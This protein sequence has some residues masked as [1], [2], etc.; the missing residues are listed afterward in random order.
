MD[1][2]AQHKFF[3][4][5]KFYA[6]N[7]GL[8]ELI[9][10]NISDVD[11]DRVAIDDGNR[12]ITFSELKD[13]AL[14]VASFLRSEGIGRGSRVALHSP[15]TTNFASIFFG[16]LRSGACCVF[17]GSKLTSKEISR[18]LSIIN[19][20]LIISVEE[21]KWKVHQAVED[22]DNSFVNIISV[23]DLLGHFCLFSGNFLPKLPSD[24]CGDDIAVISSSSGTTGQ[25]KGVVLSHRNLVSNVLQINYTLQTVLDSSSRVATPLPFCH[26][27]GATVLLCHSLYIRAT[28]FTSKD[29]L[30]LEFL[31]LIESNEIDTA[32]VIPSILQLLSIESAVDN[33]DLTSLRR[34]ICGASP[35][36][37]EL[38]RVVH[39]RFGCIIS[40]GYGMTETS[41]V[42]HINIDEEYA[43][44]N[45]GYPVIGTDVMISSGFGEGYHDVS[46]VFPIRKTC[47]NVV[48]EIWVRGPQVM[49]EYFE[50]EEATKSSFSNGWL[51][52]GDLGMIDSEGRLHII[53]RLKN[54]INYRGYQV[55]PLELEDALLSLDAV[56]D[57]V[58]VGVV[59]DLDSEEVPI[60]FVVVSDELTVT[61]QEVIDQANEQL[62]NYKRIRGIC[63]L[64]E[65]PRLHSG[66]VDRR[67]LLQEFGSS[68]VFTDLNFK[69]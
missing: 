13:E 22:Q 38:A 67:R 36:S 59:R 61:P 14:S 39:R 55:S 65:I 48:G 56:H 27:F 37:T 68:I 17:V 62:A 26:I 66:K 57:A 25:P 5:S 42:T 43:T 53:D 28:Q 18:Q 23:E 69:N 54:I 19:V 9:L 2:S 1:N 52:T 21:E 33:Y 11:S 10:E 45:V 7:I 47:T 60:A 35:L 49:V 6:P 15:N 30:L 29:F 8:F 3:S 50:N 46:D 41:P 32:F 20:D 34:L 31:Q 12:K 44:G 4:R 63:L 16:I 40:Q 64:R 58:V 51:R 24:I